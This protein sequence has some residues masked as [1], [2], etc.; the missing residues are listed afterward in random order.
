MQNVLQQCEVLKLQNVCSERIC[1]FNQVAR[2]LPKAAH[3]SYIYYL[4]DN[5]QE[6]A[7]HISR[8]LNQYLLIEYE[9]V[10][11]LSAAVVM[12]YPVDFKTRVY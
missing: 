1:K 9:L 7:V 6:R 11:S 5:Y 4:L 2:R 10:V 8:E 3:G 12:V